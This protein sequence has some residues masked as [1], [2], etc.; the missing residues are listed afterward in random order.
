MPL[1]GGV[2][3][4]K[5]A[6]GNHTMAGGECADCS[7]KKPGLQRRLVIGASNDPLELEADQIADQVLAKP[8][9]PAVNG[10]PPHIQRFSGQP[11]RQPDTAPATVEQALATPGRP[12]EP[13]LRQDM[14]QRFGHDFSRVRVHTDSVAEQSA[15]DVN[16]HAYTVG[17]DMVFA[18]GQFAPGTHE[19]RRL[20]AHELTHVAQ[21]SGAD[22][23]R[24]G[25]I[26]EKRDLSPTAPIL[27]PQRTAGNRAVNALLQRSSPLL[28]QRYPSPNRNP[29][30]T[31][32]PIL[33]PA[34]KIAWISKQRRTVD[35]KQNPD[36]DRMRVGELLI[37]R[38]LLD[39]VEPSALRNMGA[40][41]ITDALTKES[42]AVDDSGVIQV[43]FRATKIGAEHAEMRFIRAGVEDVIIR[44]ETHVE[45]SQE[46]FGRQL[47]EATQYANN[48]YHAANLYMAKVGPL[49]REGWENV[50][51][52]LEK[53]D[54]GNPFNEIVLHLT[55]T[56]LAGL[57]GGRVLEVM[58]HLK[59][60]VPLTEGLKELTIHVT[61][62][63][64]HAA[65]PEAHTALPQDPA[66]WVDAGREQI[67]KEELEVGTM[68]E[69]MI[70]ANNENR[71]GFFRDFDVVGAVHA[72]LTINGQPMRSLATTTIP[73]AEDF[74]K[75]IW[76]GFL[77][78]YHGR[79]DISDADAWLVIMH[80][81]DDIGEDG[82]EFVMTSLKEG[83]E[84]TKKRQIS[85][86]QTR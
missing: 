53:A 86:G 33:D 25:Q 39:H 50:K 52:T 10:A 83:Y 85:G 84:L 36:T 82:W 20:I 69:D 60:G 22:G 44:L 56:F 76:K 11:N 70:K 38:V 42:F 41:F 27:A 23:N 63:G 75:M 12:L 29:G 5:C 43:N 65:M 58:E 13:P 81:L 21:Q 19:G 57:A 74:E 73:K 66:D 28:L 6:C 51:K 61:E 15:R 59:Q 17:R 48:A 32:T 47:Q 68:L 3:Q 14:E 78:G 45:M 37:V 77:V 30:M 26:N 72:A 79:P 40:M 34:P 8:A 2:L 4:R 54:A 35:G 67:E 18:S 62:A 31:V 7:K 46:A 71:A 9:H 80:R 24:V 16:A 1:H 55:I 64:L 49:Y